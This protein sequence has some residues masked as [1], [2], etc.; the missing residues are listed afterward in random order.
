MRIVVSG[1][2]GFIGRAIVGALQARGDQVTALT[3]SPQAARFDEGVQIA[4]FDPMGAPDSAPFDGADAVVH[5]AGETVAGRWTEKKKRAIYDS[6]VVGT[7]TVVDSI[8]ASRAKPRILIAA[9]AS[10]YYGD[11]KDEPLLETSPPGSDF[12]A[13]VC[14]DWERETQRARSIG[15]RTACL[16]QGIVLGPGGGALS[17]MLPPFRF[18]GGGPYG[19]G[20]QWMPWIHLDDDVAL[21]LYA[22]DNNLEGAF[23]AVSPD[24]ATSARL[25]HAIGYALRRP[26]LAY[27]PGIALYTVLGEFASTLLASQL[28]LPDRV[29]SAGF[30]FKHELLEHAL[31]D[32]LARGSQREPD[33]Q[34]FEDERVVRAPLETIFAFF[35]DPGN[36]AQLTPPEV[37]FKMNAKTPGDLRRGSVMEYS[38]KVHGI[39]M[40][41]E[42]LITDWQAGVRFVDHQV[43]GPYELWRHEHRFAADPGGTRVRDLV[44]YSLPLAPLS[45]L[46]LP[47]V[48]ADLRTIFAYRRAAVARLLER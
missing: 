42:S 26:A 27:A 35:S 34:R 1:A 6:R 18:F 3:R 29:L 31:L 48:R 17:E 25:A 11:R 33:L 43:R 40:K 37:D 14:V 19:N 24:V 39:R 28:A 5:L 46:A 12:L 8:A 4:R 32:I 9:S 13:K 44:A 7:R 23:N 41:W 20:S 15:L 30:R 21:F 2:S 45:G 16:R 36:L 22:L 10:G 47:L 38:L